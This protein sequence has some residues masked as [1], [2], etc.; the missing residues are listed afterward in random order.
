MTTTH[1]VVEDLVLSDSTENVVINAPV[2]KIDLGK[3]LTQLTDAEYQACAVPDHK[4][5]GWSKNADGDLVS[6]NVEMIGGALMIQRGQAGGRGRRAVDGSRRCL[7]L[8]SGAAERGRVADG[9]HP[10]C[11]GAGPGRGDDQ[12]L[13]CEK[14]DP[15]GRGP[16]NSRN[17]TSAKTVLTDAGAVTVAVPRDP[18][19]SFEPQLVPKHARRPAVHREPI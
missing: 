12:H 6:I 9:G 10:G 5:C 16:G 4:A 15:A 2:E 13:G 19:G 11:A 7:R 18:N 3:W 1:E 14:H 8:R 17:G